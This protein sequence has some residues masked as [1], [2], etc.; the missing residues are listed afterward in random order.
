MENPYLVLTR[1]AGE[2]I[3]LQV[4]DSNGTTTVIN[5]DILEQKNKIGIEAPKDV[6]ILRYELISKADQIMSIN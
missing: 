6:L 3:T 1:K 5:I 4:P 2:S